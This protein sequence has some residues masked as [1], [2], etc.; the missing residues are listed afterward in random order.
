MQSR[1]D[2]KKQARLRK[3]WKRAT[4]KYIVLSVVT[5]L[6]LVVGGLALLLTLVFN[7][8]TST[9]RIWRPWPWTNPARPSS[10]PGCFWVRTA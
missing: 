2:Q 3:K 9:C 10:C 6:L 8:P 7:G 5:A 1:K 4:I